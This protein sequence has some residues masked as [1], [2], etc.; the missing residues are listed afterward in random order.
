MNQHFNWLPTEVLEIMPGNTVELDLELAACECQGKWPTV[1]IWLGNNQVYNG[2][3]IKSKII[4][5]RLELLENLTSLKI[6]MYGKTDKDTLVDNY[7]NIIQNQSL[8]LCKLLLN[9]VDV[10]KNK[11]VYKG[12]F[13]MLLS[14]QKTRFFEDNNIAT[15]VTDYNFY[16]NGTWTLLLQLPILTGI[17]KTVATTE[18]YEKIDYS[19]SMSDIIDKINTFTRKTQ[20]D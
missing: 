12:I 8:H 20:N 6:I 1:E 4:K 16:E 14:E 7:G 10:I 3:I 13:K 11:F 17:V 19:D 5:T 15:E 2:P 18:M 9:G